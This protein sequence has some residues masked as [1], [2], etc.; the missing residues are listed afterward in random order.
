[1]CGA[2]RFQVENQRAFN[3]TGDPGPSEA[4]ATDGFYVTEAMTVVWVKSE[5]T[6]QIVS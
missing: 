3:Y 1:M 5:G 6:D 2:P 4:D